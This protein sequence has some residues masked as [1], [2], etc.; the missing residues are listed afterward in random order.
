MGKRIY[1]DSINE[2]Q[3]EFQN[4]VSQ[5]FIASLEFQGEWYVTKEM[6]RDWG[7]Q[8]IEQIVLN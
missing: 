3:I 4:D 8:V 2:K 1:N 6:L 5:D 7:Y